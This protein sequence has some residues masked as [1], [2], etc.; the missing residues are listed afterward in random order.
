MLVPAWCQTDCCQELV[1]YPLFPDAIIGTSDGDGE[2]QGH[3]HHGRGFEEFGRGQLLLESRIGDEGDGIGGKP[4]VV[5]GVYR[6][7]RV[8]PQ[9]PTSM[10]AGLLEMGKK[11]EEVHP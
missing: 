3:F 5:R 2:P 7:D 4:C 10:S 6:S 9:L 1:S 11:L 8:I